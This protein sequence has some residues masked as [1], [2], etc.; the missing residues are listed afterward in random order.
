MTTVPPPARKPR[1]PYTPPRS[2][3]L[4]R[5]GRWVAARQA[6]LRQIAGRPGWRVDDGLPVVYEDELPP[7]SDAEYSEWFATSFVDGVRMGPLRSRP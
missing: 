1:Q 6:L 2:V 3:V 4:T 5:Y 7:M